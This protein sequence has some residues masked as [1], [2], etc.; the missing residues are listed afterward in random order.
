MKPR[1]VGWGR[2]WEGGSGGRGQ[3]CACLFIFGGT[4]SVAA[5]AL[6]WLWWAGAILAVACRFLIA[7]ASPAAERGLRG[8]RPSVV[9][10]PGLSSYGSW[11]L[12]HRLS[13]C[14][15]RLIALGMWGSFRIRDWTHV[16]C[17]GR[18][19]LYNWATRE[20]PYF[21]KLP[22][23]TDTSKSNPTPVDFYLL[24]FSTESLLA[25]TEDHGFRQQCVCAHT[26]MC[27]SVSFIYPYNYF[28]WPSN[29]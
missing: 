27:V 1:G 17:I 11:P 19:I 29:G 5:W 26:H 16:S 8:T 15:T 4:E 24:P 13:S 9:V 25:Y 20:T 22:V 23:Y 6:L 7:V 21:F 18:Q 3:V 28:S 10:V 14:G 12:E 2:R